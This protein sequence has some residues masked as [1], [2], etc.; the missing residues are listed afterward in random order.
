[1]IP[2][3]DKVTAVLQRN[4]TTEKRIQDMLPVLAHLPHQVSHS[5]N[6]QQ[7]HFMT[8]SLANLAGKVDQN[9]SRDQVNDLAVLVERIKA[10]QHHDK[11]AISTL[12]GHGMQDLAE[13]KQIAEASKCMLVTLINQLPSGSTATS[14]GTALLAHNITNQRQSSAKAAA[15]HPKALGLILQR[16]LKVLHRGLNA[17]LLCLLCATPFLQACF[18]SINSIS[19]AP[20]MLIDSKLTFVDALNRE[21]SLQFQQ[22][23]YL[24]VVSA[25]LQRQFQDC[26]GALRISR[27]RFAMFKDTRST[28]RGAMIPFEDWESTIGPGSVYS[29]RCTSATRILRKATGRFAT[30]VLHVA[31]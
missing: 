20:R 26:P 19:R 3:L 10:D 12:I 8:A 11:S 6:K 7:V 5:S 24:P 1:M 30:H 21:F 23:R 22:F 13:F 25:W 17:I 27:G 16:L 9:A 29:C 28:G 31:L 18:R 15:S 2:A 4:A 14:R